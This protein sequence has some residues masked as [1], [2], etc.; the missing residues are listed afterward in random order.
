MASKITSGGSSSSLH[1]ITSDANGVDEALP[2]LSPESIEIGEL[3]SRKPRQSA[4]SSSSSL[5]STNARVKT[6]DANNQTAL[7]KYGSLLLLVGQMVGLV[8]VMRYSRTHN[9][10]GEMYLASTAVFMMEVRNISALP[11]ME[12]LFVLYFINI[13]ISNAL[14]E[15]RNNG[16]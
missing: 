9:N 5:S 3:Y 8:L 2:L 14:F 13:G 11:P 1:V 15:L 12:D 7:I 10:N 6:T 4:P 16:N